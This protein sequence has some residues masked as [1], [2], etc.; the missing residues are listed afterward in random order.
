MIEVLQTAIGYFVGVF[1][2]VALGVVGGFSIVALFGALAS[3]VDGWW[4]EGFMASL[5]AVALAFAGCLL[6]AAVW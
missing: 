1:V 6:A 3:F 2:I 4:R 5:L